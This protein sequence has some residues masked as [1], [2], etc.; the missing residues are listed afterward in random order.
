LAAGRA[1][2]QLGFGGSCLCHGATAV[3]TLV[4]HIV[5]VVVIVVIVVVLVML[6]VLMMVQT[7]RLSRWLLG[8]AA[9]DHIN[10]NL[11]LHRNG[12]LNDT[13]GKSE[14]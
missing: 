8:I 4:C 6:V 7:T 1:G 14:N 2:V 11:I 9:V 10:V 13:R 3:A 12:T 5:V